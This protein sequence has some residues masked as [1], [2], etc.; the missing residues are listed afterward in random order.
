MIKRL[1]AA[2]AD[3][4]RI[5]AVI[6]GSGVNQDGRTDGITVP[7]GE[8]QARLI[9]QVCARFDCDPGS[10]TYVEAHG[11]GTAIG[12]PIELGALASVFGGAGRAVPCLVGSVKAN[13]GHLEA[14]A[15]IAAVIKT[16]LCLERGQVPPVANLDKM[17]PALRLWRNGGWTCRAG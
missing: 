6:R 14:A 15:G 5:H 4:D 1:S 10:V 13:I 7:N 16:A 9:R 3:G 17:N 12:D 8:A 11:T 2:L